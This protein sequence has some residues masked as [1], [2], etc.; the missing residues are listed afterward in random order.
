MYIDLG[1]H[2]ITNTDSK[3]LADINTS[4]TKYITTLK[5]MLNVK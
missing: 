3:S 1:T 4:L 5:E 2:V